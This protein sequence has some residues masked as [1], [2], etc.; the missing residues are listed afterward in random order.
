MR[1]KRKTVHNSQNN[2]KIQVLYK[3][4]YLLKKNETKNETKWAFSIFSKQRKKFT[5]QNASSVFRK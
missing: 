2:Y 5:N 1:L 4:L 3:R